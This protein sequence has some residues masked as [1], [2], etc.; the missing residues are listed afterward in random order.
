MRLIAAVALGVGVVI[1]VIATL[2]LRDTS[3]RDSAADQVQTA[4]SPTTA[5]VFP[6]P[7]PS[8]VVFFRQDGGSVLS[9]AVTPGRRLRLQA[10]VL[11]PDGT[12]TNGLRVSFSV[13]GVGAAAAAC[14]AGC[15]RGALVTARQPRAIDVIV[16]GH[17]LDT[18]WR[19]RVPRAW[20][21][22][23]G[24]SLIREAGRVWR[25]LHSL[26]YVEHLASDPRHALTSHWRV[27]APDRAAYQVLGGSAGIVI[28]G[29]RWDQS[30]PGGRWIKSAQTATITQPVPF[31]VSAVDAHIVGAGEVDGRPVWRVSFFDPGTP[32]WFEVALDQRTKR[33]LRLTM[34][35]T[36]HFMSHS[37]SAFNRATPITPP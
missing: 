23:S 32:G 28:G 33:T 19:I 9:L 7:P 25:S 16:S 1:A 10:S 20:P 5:A 13:D 26:A 18:R 22:P 24:A 36:A 8:A 3:S 37:Y 15:Y 29:V 4:T 34:M 6:A 31:W 12:G 17:R 11:G 21:A 2:L 14:G 30:A 27:S 35:A